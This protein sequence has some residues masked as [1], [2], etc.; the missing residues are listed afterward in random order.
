MGR[1]ARLAWEHGVTEYR[2]SSGSRPGVTTGHI[3]LGVLR[4]ETCAG[5]LILA[6]L[7]LDLLWARRVTE[8]VLLH[9]RRQDDAEVCTAW[10][11]VPH[12]AAA[13]RVVEL[14]LEEANRYSGTYPIG[15][16]HLLLAL[17]QVP[18]GMGYGLLHYFG[19][20]VHRVRAAR[21]TLWE[22]LRSPE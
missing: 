1:C 6:R 7:Q 12:T 18:E 3:L 4:E 14:S 5:G 2:S 13:M 8:F 10:G 17:L 20:D 11:D 16:E 19:L 21:D 22:L 15:T 9:S